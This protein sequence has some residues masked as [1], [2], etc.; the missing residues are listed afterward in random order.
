MD[1]AGNLVRSQALAHEAAHLIADPRLHAELV[2]LL[3]RLRMADGEVEVGHAMLLEEAEHVGELDP[4]LAAALLSFAANLPVFRLEGAAAVEL[5]ERVEA[6]RSRA[7]ADN[8]RAECWALATTMVGDV[9]GP[10]VV[11][12]ARGPEGRGDWAPDAPAAGR[13]SGWRSTRSRT[14]LTWPWEVTLRGP[15][16]HLRSR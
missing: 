13:S 12:L 5:T 9:I 14:L 6:G 4:A 8:G 3:G 10:P 16:R 7:P 1:A 2:I 15:L 11:E